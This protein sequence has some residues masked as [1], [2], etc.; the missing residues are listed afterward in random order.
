MAVLSLLEETREAHDIPLHIICD[1]QY[2]INAVTKWM[3][4]WK[5][6][7]WRKADG[8]TVSNRQLLERIDEQLEGR[9]LTF[10]WV[11]GHTGHPLNEDVDALA[12]GYA[13]ALQSGLTPPSGPGFSATSSTTEV[14]VA[15]PAETAQAPLF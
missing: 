15:G 4:G 10:E 7:G 9:S 2:V 14:D 5:Q 6:K 1:S 12:R 3:P 11:R 13:E 8:K